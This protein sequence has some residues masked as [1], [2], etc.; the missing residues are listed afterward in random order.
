MTVELYKELLK[1]LKYKFDNEII[2]KFEPIITNDFN[3][4][5]I[6]YSKFWH[7]CK[8]E[9]KN[10]KDMRSIVEITKKIFLNSYSKNIYNEI[11]NNRNKFVKIDKLVDAANNIVPNITPT[12]SELKIENKKFL[13]DKVGIET[14][15]GL[16]LSSIL[17][18]LPATRVLHF[19]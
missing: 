8:L 18:S 17:L 12:K 6:I 16:L 10:Q 14:D 3:K 19:L 4:D 15:Q 1:K 5:K 13:K 11:T 2:N 9:N 7:N